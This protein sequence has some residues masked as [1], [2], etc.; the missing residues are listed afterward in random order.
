VF[1][2]LDMH[3]RFTRPALIDSGNLSLEASV[4]HRG[5]RLRISSCN[6]NDA[7]G[8]RVAMATSSALLVEGG[9]RELRNGR[10]PEEIL[11]EDGGAETVLAD[12]ANP[13]GRPQGSE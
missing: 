4:N 5:R 10:L 11:A 2:T 7:G 3:I 12:R 13:D 8:K 6:V 1:A 9:V